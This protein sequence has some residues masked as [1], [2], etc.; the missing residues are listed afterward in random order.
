ME[1]HPRWQQVGGSAADVYERQLVPGMFAP[2]APIL[3]DMAGVQ[4]GERVLDVACGTGVVARVAAARVARGGQVTGLDINGAMLAVAR[5]QPVPA[6]VPVTWIEA[7]AQDMPLP[8]ESFDVVLCQHGLQQ[9]PDRPGAL[10]EMRRVLAS[11][12]RLA[13]CVWSHIDDNPGMAALVQALERHVGAE[14]A[15]NR[16]APFRLSDADELHALLQGAGFRD[17]VVST[18]VE[19]TRFPSPEAF[20]EAQLA[21]TPLS[22]LGVLAEATRQTIIADVRATLEPWLQDDRFTVP[23]EAHVAFARK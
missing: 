23:M 20:V 9:V 6:D 10:R 4:P 12:G 5:G 17:I 21:A 16:R 14:A 1:S 8:P 13:L 22:T 3:I 11:D 2:W 18:V 7:N 19:P 15:N